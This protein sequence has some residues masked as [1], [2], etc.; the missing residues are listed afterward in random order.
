MA[1]SDLDPIDTIADKLKR[2]PEVHFH[3][4]NDVCEIGPP[5]EGG[6]R[7]ELLSDGDGWVVY[8][9]ENGMHEHFSK[10]EEAIEFIGFCLSDSC[11]LREVRMPF[12][13]RNFV[14]FKNGSVWDR[15]YEF[16]FLRSPFPFR[17]TER[18]F[19]NTLIEG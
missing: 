5:N 13:Q 7:I 10:S 19:Q 2:Y 8:L 3:R 1:S 14:E 6:F 15:V 12:L 16:G 9:G 4:N 18:V 17:L 11:R